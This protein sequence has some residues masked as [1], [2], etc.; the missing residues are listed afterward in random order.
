MATEKCVPNI[1]CYFEK[2]PTHLNLDQDKVCKPIDYI[3][4]NNTINIPYTNTGIPY[5]NN[6]E[7]F[8]PID[9]DPYNKCGT[10]RG[11]VGF[12]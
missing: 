7:V 11:G 2:W 12:H 5:E 4:N 9:S 1:P 6:Q 10:S 3:I 8:F